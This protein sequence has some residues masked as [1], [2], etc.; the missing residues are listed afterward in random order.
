MWQERLALLKY[1]GG[2]KAALFWLMKILLRIE[3]YFF[4]SID[5]NQQQSLSSS[6]FGKGSKK[7]PYRFISLNTLRDIAIYPSETIEQINSQSGRGVSQL[8][9]RNAGVYAFIE[10]NQVMSQANIDRNTVIQVDSPTHLDIHLKSGDVFLGYLYTYQDY[11]GRGMAAAL[12]ENICENLSNC[13]YSR[14]VTHIRSTN[15]ASLNTFRKGGWFKIGWI[16]ISVKGHLLLTHGLSKSGITVF[17]TK[18][19]DQ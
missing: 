8:V 13:G 6:S 2:F 4:Y 3:V 15:V 19:A 10:E 14:I 7:I 12:L 16:I 18:P 1:K 5:L 11:R 17:P 9:H